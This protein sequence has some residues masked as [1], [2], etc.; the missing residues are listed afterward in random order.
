MRD[1]PGRRRSSSNCSSSCVMFSLGGTPS[2]TH[3][4]PPPCDSPNVVTRNRRPKEL[5]VARVVTVVARDVERVREGSRGSGGRVRERVGARGRRRRRASN[6]RGAARTRRERTD[7][8]DVRLICAVG[9]G[10][11]ARSGPRGAERPPS[12]A[13]NDRREGR[14]RRPRGVAA[15]GRRRS[16]G[17]HRLRGGGRRARRPMP[18]EPR[19]RRSLARA[20]ARGDGTGGGD[21]RRDD[22]IRRDWDVRGRGRKT[23]GASRGASGSRRGT[24]R[25]FERSDVDVKNVPRQP[26]FFQTGSSRIGCP[27]P[28]RNV[29]RLAIRRRSGRTKTKTSSRRFVATIRRDDERRASL[30]GYVLSSHTRHSRHSASI[31]ASFRS[32]SSAT[33]VITVCGPS[34]R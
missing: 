12:R 4:T 11:R 27:A 26:R 3:P 24:A 5:P 21:D 33:N 15:A 30:P 17:T 10:R 18:G 14:A 8:D 16:G 34:L 13:G 7:S 1:C 6:G 2:T 22:H 28:T 31:P 19:R 25:R 20:E 32:C 23:P 29:T 9:V